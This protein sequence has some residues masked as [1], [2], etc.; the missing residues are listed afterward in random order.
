MTASALPGMLT[1]L[2]ELLPRTFEYSNVME[3][4]LRVKVARRIHAIEK[5]DPSE[6]DLLMLE[7]AARQEIEARGWEWRVNRTYLGY[8]AEVWPDVRKDAHW[9]ESDISSA[10]ALTSALLAALEAPQ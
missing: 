5:D 10:M 9:G 3:P 4:L 1:R 7:A 8:N 2:S 6:F